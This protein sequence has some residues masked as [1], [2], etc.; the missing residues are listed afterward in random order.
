MT[1]NFITV[2]LLLKYKLKIGR[3]YHLFF[4]QHRSINSSDGNFSFS[5]TNITAHK[6]VHRACVVDHVSR[7]CLYQ[8]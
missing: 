1:S 3:Q 6:P 5:K 4:R 2:K 7:N 8:D